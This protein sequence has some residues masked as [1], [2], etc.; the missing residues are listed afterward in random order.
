MERHETSTPSSEELLAGLTPPD[1]PPSGP[2]APTPASRREGAT[3]GVAATLVALAVFGAAHLVSPSAPFPPLAIGQRVLA[4]V[5]GPLASFAID[6]LGHWALRL[7]VIGVLAATLALG[8]AAGAWAATRPGRALACAGAGL[9]MALLALLGA[10]GG[11]G[12]LSPLG[13]VLLVLTAALVYAVVL[14]GALDRLERDPVPPV[15]GPGLGRARREFL[16]AAVGGTVLLGAAFGLRRFVGGGGGGRPLARPADA[17]PITRAPAPAAEPAATSSAFAIPGLPPEITPNADHY[18]VDESIIDPSVDAGSWRLKIAGRAELTYEQLLAM[19]AVEQVV[20][21]TCI[22]NLVGGD[23]V[24]TARWTGVPL[25]D[26]LAKAGGPG[27]DAVRVVFSA[28]GGYTDSLPVDKAMDPATIVAYGMNGVSLPRSHGFPARVIA[29]GI[30]GMKNV[31]WLEKIEVTDSEYEG[32]WARKGWDNIA[33]IHTSSRIDV[34]G[35][36][37]TV[38]GQVVL[39][40]TAWAGDRGIRRVEVSV[41]GGRTWLE[42]ELRRPLAGA[43]WRQWR[44]VL[45]AGPDRRLRVLVRAV[46]GTGQL[47]TSQQAQPYPAGSTGWDEIG[48]RALPGG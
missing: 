23:L 2:A 20:T 4:L 10:G 48:V 37:D 7:F 32:Y 9:V 29:P 45:P 3:A 26:V 21:L 40:G 47:Q 30:Y 43:A 28:A 44:L 25:R 19:P 34:P 13:Y 6:V 42:T 41:D 22:S 31:K 12:G 11:Q 18:T 36:G 24:S 15:A 33:R 14:R 39:A 5:P 46:D 16:R 38:K 27:P 35:G 8:G 17:A 1:P